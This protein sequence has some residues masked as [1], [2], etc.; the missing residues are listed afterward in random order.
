VVKKLSLGYMLPKSQAYI[1][2]AMFVGSK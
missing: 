1:D 2:K